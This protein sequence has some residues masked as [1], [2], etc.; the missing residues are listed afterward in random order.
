[1]GGDVTG[2]GE[3]DIKTLLKALLAKLEGTATGDN[4]DTLM[5]KIRKTRPATAR[6][7]KRKPRLLVILPIA[8]KSLSRVSI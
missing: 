5:I 6:T 2:D 8:L 4:A 7:T 1:M 3:D